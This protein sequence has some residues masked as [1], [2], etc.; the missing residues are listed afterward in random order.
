[1][2]KTFSFGQKVSDSEN[3]KLS[4]ALVT[5]VTDNYISNNLIICYNAWYM[6]QRNIGSDE[7]DRVFRDRQTE[8]WRDELLRT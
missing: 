8:C 3:K 1:M 5:D 7:L 2:S 6:V 4:S